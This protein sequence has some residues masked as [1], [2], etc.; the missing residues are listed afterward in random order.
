M[1]LMDGKRLAE[2]IYGELR[3]AISHSGRTYR[4]AV[5][6]V[7]EDPVIAKFVGQKK[8]IG[9]SIGVD[10]RVYP[11]PESI[12]TNELRKRIAEIVHEEKN[13]GVIVQ[14]P[15]PPH[16]NKQS[17][18]N[19]VVPEKDV[20]VLSAR[21]VGDFTVGKSKI[22]PTVVGA[23]QALFKEYA[24]D[25]KGKSVAI[26]GA[27]AL[28]G[29]P[30]SIWLMRESSIVT[31]ITEETHHPEEIVKRADIVVSGIGKPGYVTGD[32]IQEGAAVIDAGTSES[33]GKILGD[34]DFDSVS[35]KARLLTP[36]PG[37]VGPLTVAM[38]FKNL[39]LLAEK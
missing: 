15:L 13:T 3:E 11:F 10:V 26:L 7:G 20:D 18:L 22:A 4:L 32:M 29:K 17:I 6:V 38:I 37:G 16:I 12:S 34:I 27:G 23:I 35:K 30:V 21:A 25:P 28:V 1:I 2:K 14:L 33:E 36:V 5:I 19:S 9:E 31:T 8:K 39:L 24:I